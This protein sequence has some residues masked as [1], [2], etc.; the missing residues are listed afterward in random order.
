MFGKIKAFFSG[1][2]ASVL[3]WWDKKKPQLV[4][5]ACN[6]V[7][8]ARPTLTLLLS[9]EKEK[10]NAVEIADKIIKEIKNGIRMLDKGNQYPT[11][12][13]LICGIVETQRFRVVA[14]IGEMINSVAPNEIADK[15][16]EEIKKKIREI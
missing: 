9:V 16:I 10:I 2:V 6:A 11:V 5:L 14:Y 15:I 13:S 3:S 7:E 1:L 12:V 8:T 4:D